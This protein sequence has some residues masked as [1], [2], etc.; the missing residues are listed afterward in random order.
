MYLCW[1]YNQTAHTNSKR[2]FHGALMLFSN[3]GPIMVK[4]SANA[5]GMQKVSVNGLHWTFQTVVQ[6]AFKDVFKL[7][8]TFCSYLEY[9]P[10]RFLGTLF[11]RS[12]TFI[13]FF[14]HK[15][16]DFPQFKQNPIFDLP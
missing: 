8:K 4:C 5:Y 1:G 10:G 7:G 9:S 13:T 16:V 3:A 15:F 12:F 6:A 11:E 2:G 14:S